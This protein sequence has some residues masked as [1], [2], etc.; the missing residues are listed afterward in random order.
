MA[1]PVADVNL[2]R[3]DF[4]TYI[5]NTPI[6]DM[7]ASMFPDPK[8]PITP[9]AF[10]SDG[11]QENTA[12]GSFS[13]LSNL[14][15]KE[16]KK[17]FNQNTVLQV[18]V[19]Q[20]DTS[21][22]FK[23]FSLGVDNEDAAA[24]GQSG[25]DKAANAVTKGLVL[26]GTTFLQGTAGLVA[27]V[28]NAIADGKLS[29]FYD[30]GFNRTLDGWNKQLENKYLPNYYSKSE[31][32]ASWYSPD[33]WLTVNFLFDK[34]VKNL[35][36]AAGAYFSGGVASKALSALGSVSKLT[37]VG[38][39]FEAAAEAEKLLL[40]QKNSFE[41]INDF[42]Q[43]LKTISNNA[44]NKYNFLNTG[45][46]VLAAGLSTV[47][48]ASFESMANAAQGREA[49]IASFQTKYGRLPVGEEMQN[50]DAQAGKIG[51]ASFLLNTALLSVTNYIQFPK[52]MGTSYKAAK[53]IANDFAV[54]TNTIVKD[55]EKGEFR[56]LNFNKAARIA[57]GV[58]T[59]ASYAFSP[60]EAFEEV[61]QTAIQFGT[62]SYYDKKYRGQEANF[63][64]DL[65]GE[66]YSKAF[67]TKEGI[68]SLI[69]GGLS[70]AIME[71]PGR[72]RTNKTLKANTA[73]AISDLN[74]QSFSKFM[75]DT[76]DAVNRGITLQEQQEAA[77]RQG[78]ILEAK[79]LERDYAHNYLMPRVKYGRYDLVKD[80][81]QSYKR[82]ASTEEGF[83]QLQAEGKA[84]STDTVASFMARLDNF[85]KHAD[86]M[87]VFYESFN[88]RYKGIVDKDK[89]RVYSDK[90]IDKM[91]YA[92]S[93]VE[94]Y[95]TR[96]K[97]LST[98][99]MASGIDTTKLGQFEAED[100]TGEEYRTIRDQIHQLPLIDT[101]KEA[102]EQDLNDFVELALRRKHFLQE[103][104]NLKDNPAEH[105]E[106]EAEESTT[107][108][109][110]NG[111]QKE[112]ASKETVSI[113]T[114]DGE[115][116]VKIGEEYYLGRLV[117]FDTKG[118][119]VYRFPRL[120][121]IGKNEDG[122]I[123]IKQSD[124]KIRD[125]SPEEFASYKLGRVADVQKRK[126]AKYFLEHIN[127]IFEFNFGKTKGGKK[128]GRIQY[129]PAK[130]ILE[131]IYKDSKGKIKRRE[132]TGDQFKAKKGYTEPLIKSIGTLTPVQQEALD[133]MAADKEDERIQKKFEQRLQIISEL[134]TNHRE[135]I[136]QINAK[137]DENNKSLL[138]SEGQ[139]S[140]LSKKVDKGE[141]DENN[142]FKAS[143]RT[144]VRTAMKLSRMRDEWTKE[145]ESLL[146]E[147]EELEMGL[148]YFD[149]LAADLEELPTNTSEFLEE[150]KEQQKDVEDLI[151]ATGNSINK[152]A[153]L[154][155]KIEDGIASAIS[156]INSIID[157]FTSTYPKAPTDSQSQ[158]LVDFVRANPNFLK[159]HPGFL[160]DL[161]SLEALVT[162]SEDKEI[163]V[164]QQELNK[165]QGQ[166]DDLQTTL[167][168]LESEYRAKGVVYEKF[169]GIAD[170]S[171]DDKKK[172]QEFEANKKLQQ[173]LF[174]Q[175]KDQDKD[176]G[177]PNT[178]GDPGRKL[179]WAATAKHIA[180]LFRSSTSPSKDLKPHHIREQALL[181]NIKILPPELRANLRIV[182]ITP[183]TQEAMGLPGLIDKIGGDANTIVAV[184]AKTNEGK[185]EYIDINGQPTTFLD[186]AV[187][188]TMPTESLTN[189]SGNQRYSQGTEE[190][191]KAHQK[192]W[193][194]KRAE[195]L[196]WT[197]DQHA[198]F[199]FGISRGI[200]VIT[201]REED[202]KNK[203]EQNNAVGTLIQQSDLSK[204][205]LVQVSVNGTILHELG[206]GENI[207]QRDVN[208]PIGNVVIQNQDTIAILNNRNFTPSEQEGLYKVLRQFVSNSTNG[209]DR[210]LAQYLQG[211]FHFSR[212]QEGK[213]PA[214]NQ[215]WIEE[216]KLHLGRN[217]SVSFYPE[218]FD[219]AKPEV[220]AFL[221]GVYNNANNTKLKENK[222]YEE[223]I[224][225]DSKGEPVSVTWKSYQH[226]L[227]SPTHDLV[228][229]DSS[230]LKGKDRGLAPLTTI[231][232]P[233]NKEVNALDSNFEQKYAT[234]IG[235]FYPVPEKKIIPPAPKEIK[236]EEPKQEKNKVQTPAQAKTAGNY[237]LDGKTKNI[238]S[239]KSGDLAFTMV[240]EGDGYNIQILG[241]IPESVK[242]AIY[243]QPDYLA[244]AASN[245][246]DE[247]AVPTVANM[248]ILA[249]VK[250]A[251]Q[252]TIPEA[253]ITAE[254][255]G[256]PV[257]PNI[258][259]AESIEK[260]KELIAK[261]KASGAVRKKD[262]E[263]RLLVEGFDYVKANLDQEQSWFE[264]VLSI[265]FNR[266]RNIINAGG[267]GIAFGKFQDAAVHIWENAEIGTTYHEAFE[268]VWAMFTDEKEKAAILKE[269][270]GRTGSFVERET[271]NPINHSSSTDVQAKEQL[272]EEFRNYVIDGAKP[273]KGWLATLF[274]DLLDFIKELFHPEQ[275]IQ[276]MFQRINGG[277]YKDAA[278]LNQDNI[279]DP[280]YSII[281]N[282]KSQ[283]ASSVVEHV[284]VSLLRQINKD[285]ASTHLVELDENTALP[286][287]KLFDMV[288]DE[289]RDWY[290][291][292]AA[293]DNEND[294]VLYSKY[295]GVWNNIQNNWRAVKEATVESLRAY[296]IVAKLAEEDTDLLDETREEGKS[297]EEKNDK[298]SAEYERPTFTYDVK[299]NAPTSIK[300]LFANLTE[301]IASAAG[302][303]V[304]D[305]DKLTSLEQQ[306]KYT[307]IFNQTMGALVDVNT[308][309][310]KQAALKDLMVKYPTLRK[311]YSYLKF[312]NSSP[313]IDDWRLRVR[314]FNVFSKQQPS[315]LINYIT[316]EGE[317]FVG[318]ADL[319]DA[320]Q[321]LTKKW[322]ES[323]KGTVGKPGSII[324]IGSD[325]KQYMVK[326]DV[327]RKYP[328][329]RIED[330]LAMLN[331]IGI[332][333]TAAQ[334]NLLSGVDK[335]RFNKGVTDLKSYLGNKNNLIAANAK[336][337]DVRGPFTALAETYIKSKGEEWES[338][339]IDINGE[340]VQKSI[341]TNYISNV[342]NDINNSTSLED[343]YQRLPHLR[344][345]EYSQGSEYLKDFSNPDNKPQFKIKYIQGTIDQTKTNKQNIP[346]E[347]LNPAERLVQEINQNLEGNYYVL[348]P[349]DS[350]TEWILGMQNRVDF[351]TIY[352]QSN[353]W[354][355]INNIFEGYYQTE[356]ALFL[357]DGKLRPMAAM[358]NNYKLDNISGAIKE[359][360]QKSVADQAEFLRSY[361]KGLNNFN[362][363]FVQ[364]KFKEERTEHDLTNLL[365]YRTA[366]Y[367]IN[368][369]ETHKLFFGDPAA[370]KDPT[371][372]YKSF[373]SPREASLYGSDEYT[374]IA[375]ESFNNA[376]DIKL[377][378][379][380][381]G[382]WVFDDNMIVAV[383]DDIISTTSST[384][385]E[386]LR[387]AYTQTNSAD[388]QSWGTIAGYREIWKRAGDRWS[389]AHEAQY[390]YLMAA[391]RQ[392]MLKDG[393]LNDE[394]YRKEL[395]EED[396]KIVKHGNPHSTFFPVLKPIGSGFDLEDRPFLHKTSLVP[397]W[398]R[399]TKIDGKPTNLTTHYLRMMNQGVSYSIVTSGEKVGNAGEDSV[400]DEKGNAKTA[401]TGF[402]RLVDIPF[403][404]Y[405]IQVETNSNKSTGV[406]GTQITKEVTMN[407]LDDSGPVD[408]EG[409]NWDT[410]SEDQK[411]AA[412]PI[413]TQVRRN[414]QLLD[415]MTR[416]GY[417]KLLKKFGIID[418]GD[419]FSMPDKSLALK[420]IQDELFRREVPD[421]F[422]SALKLDSS[423]G[424][425]QV[426]LEALPNYGQIQAIILSY[427]DKLITSPK[428][429]GGA[430]VQVSGAMWE[431]IGARE[432]KAYNKAGKE[433][434]A[435]VS[436]GLKFYQPTYNADGSIKS[437]GRM[438]VLLPNWVGKKLRERG[439]TDE[440]ILSKMTPE[441]LQGVG[442]RI[443]TQEINS[444]E[445]FI[446]KGFLP[447]EYGS[448]IVVPEE[449][450][451]KA[452][453]DFDVDKLNTYLKNIH[454][455]RTG[456]IHLIEYQGDE[457]STRQFY[458][459]FFD[460]AI[461]E[462]KKLN[463]KSIEGTA[464]LFN[465]AE[466]YDLDLLSE[467]QLKKHERLLNEV[468]ASVDQ[469]SDLVE[470]L[471]D[472]LEKKGKIAADLDDVELQA[473]L[474]D[475]FV[476]R[477]HE[478][479]LEN[480]YFKSVEQLILL[481]ENFERL[482]TPNS[483]DQLKGLR[484]DLL[485]ILPQEGGTDKSILNPLFM[486]QTR[487]NFIV[488]KGGVGI[489]AVAQTNHAVNQ[490]SKVYIDA[491][492]AKKLPK[493]TQD[494]LG[495]L[496]IKL[497]H[498]TTTVAGKQVPTLSKIKNAAGQH[499]SN[500]IAQFIDGYVDIAKDPF[501]VELGATPN[502]AGTFLLLIKLGVPVDTVVYFMNQPI[503][504]SH[505]KALSS[506]GTTW[507][508][509]EEAVQT[510]LDLFATNSK[511]LQSIDEKALRS[512]IDTYTKKGELSDVK[513]A[514]QQLI[515]LEFL[516]Y[517]MM[518]NQLFEFTQ[519]TNYDTANF[520]DGGLV[521]K[522]IKK[523]SKAEQSNIFSSP[524]SY[525]NNSHMGGMRTA[526]VNSSRA[527]GTTMLK[528]S[529]PAVREQLGKV[530]D[531]FDNL[532]MTDKDYIN[533]VRKIR[534][535]F[536]SFL[537]QTQR[538][539]NKRVHELLV[540][541]NSNIATRIT[542]AIN[543]AK[544]GTAM[545]ENAFI[546]NIAVSYGA[547]T[548][549]TKGINLAIKVNGDAF[550]SD[551]IT[552]GLAELKDADR[553]LYRAVV[554][555]AF[556][557][558]GISKTAYSFSDLIPAAD[559]AEMLN[560]L[561]QNLENSAK[562][563]SFADYDGFIRNN[564]KDP[565]IVPTIKEKI[566]RDEDGR[567]VGGNRLSLGM[568]S[569]L[570]ERLGIPE[571]EQFQP[572]KLNVRNRHA[573]RKFIAIRRDKQGFGNKIKKEM[574]KKKD[575]S[576]MEVV[577]LKRIDDENGEPVTL[578]KKNNRK[579]NSVMYFPMN[580]W[581]DGYAAQEYYDVPTKSVLN[582]GTY[583]PSAEA[584]SEDV[585]NALEGNLA[586]VHQKL[587]RAIDTGEI[588]QN[589]D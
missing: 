138:E 333:F 18:P 383:I 122:T 26:A 98:Y 242:Q 509:G 67:N 507:L 46:R 504:K 342:V 148:A 249:K 477:M 416:V 511:A 167:K 469:T 497:S 462:A 526:L 258:G 237:I 380:D 520:S 195:I 429:N 153:T 588:K 186:E 428:V 494:I 8:Q 436:R 1:A 42:N 334:Y 554:R 173:M 240:Q 453:S 308:L 418:H 319:S 43:A 495:D 490:L 85:E 288:Y 175:Q 521:D 272:A 88:L 589:C 411:K 473:I 246:P 309:Q 377:Q 483:A 402:S 561:L 113:T 114:K 502:T 327:L 325:Y 248:F 259:E 539:L 302:E 279:V 222:P 420:L 62:Q 361:G 216:G 479:A 518:A 181:N 424:D 487:H 269:F 225:I 364:S 310:E 44:I 178:G 54:A 299:K 480:E 443:P 489:A 14:L 523:T 32:D 317:T 169:Q 281:P 580:A 137:I 427:V 145:N 368:N 537:L 530:V 84:A 56:T 125:V 6:P 475:I 233:L 21:G 323:F 362:T 204:K 496:S 390:Q 284:R 55:A 45:H 199:A 363:Q 91:V 359:Y 131:F 350:K 60:S 434:K 498:N 63:F 20:I 203:Y 550:T 238:A 159:I 355:K 271:G 185:L 110:Q 197:G 268:A 572:Y 146:G 360:I 528:L 417:Q 275:R 551:I 345:H 192:A 35:G 412:S 438:E 47:G 247:R 134:V 30:N 535:G 300:F 120:T 522:K 540:D 102:L 321:S 515:L 266:V 373:L 244:L 578:G 77:I 447:E 2:Q 128:K 168:G 267:A 484:K 87:N 508:Y 206:Y 236:K 126:K 448:T 298:S 372:R 303:T 305:R 337:L 341:Q 579:Y 471:M 210:R 136:N 57:K 205:G 11:A 315:P 482:I 343:L 330:K 215:M 16:P 152:T 70:G 189:L 129:N 234:I 214:R 374:N 188:A 223:I 405:G 133:A 404:Y 468:L 547:T 143:T 570:R 165:L 100:Y 399:G 124:G 544:P 493:D 446:V 401:D 316:E 403:K 558:S 422:K 190:E 230:P 500:I 151:L 297:D 290:E 328:T 161:R 370:Y 274:S 80:D 277:Y 356:K 499:I 326:Q 149:D 184:Y 123:K 466:G 312:D 82:L 354:N 156:F 24:A 150:L 395:Q 388:A 488:G 456:E 282:F 96:T 140:K 260:A 525:L 5:A 385:P 170:K 478:K 179:G 425:F 586:S 532:Y 37:S 252:S 476:D 273:K 99:L 164:P 353:F 283:V 577:L 95:S 221:S 501:I 552:E 378:E 117:K 382:H 104:T 567:I 519:A 50:I 400:Y 339:F 410:L 346:T 445:A 256:E 64:D 130:D 76:A 106:P 245:V 142:K 68:E 371:K 331:A 459:E 65:L 103:F 307:R 251:Q 332:P 556:L 463:Q 227:L 313:S 491:E 49:M 413:Y 171:K 97:E 79:D 433:Y 538:G 533:V 512:N 562:Y 584:T 437:V 335:S 211:V 517:S 440:E 147:R 78:D 555:A 144:A 464:F 31:T 174:A 553:S 285:G 340:K 158:E 176:A 481:P 452:G 53:S 352:N 92:A 575:F 516:K 296:G 241:E 458:S 527:I 3:P 457:A 212:P 294:P 15:A 132:V 166:L 154:I 193:A 546:Q 224:D 541:E 376:G 219:K 74:T 435:V 566:V 557:Q 320:A 389:N 183:K 470:L 291:V 505:L 583:K 162:S 379:G 121:I 431:E 7:N 543:S 81:I 220:M 322:I 112:T 450:T 386:S 301:T 89:Q 524:S 116:N 207:E 27:G 289:M 467:E 366:N 22:R 40:A 73:L 455:K 135:R 243:L 439:F 492:K 253:T 36:F 209:I 226:F 217:F 397:L 66:G 409:T 318:S 263:Y 119:E 534:E 200:P 338:T 587:V 304:F 111:E 33:N 506:A 564:W 324:E 573:A 394:N 548:T 10:L 90:V 232:R 23:F 261:A 563:T 127:D 108:A 235:D 41:S 17:G 270:R 264:R 415:E 13:R 163:V 198:S 565:S 349:A 344:Y 93:K 172:E 569:T 375:N 59:G 71:G 208:V 139:L 276:K 414:T 582:N 34:V 571:G 408:Y 250:A 442:F 503:I 39:S 191:A 52:I 101:T 449:I 529:Q 278:P 61:S 514:E 348:I 118:N 254:I 12:D 347:K 29:S 231:I 292:Q 86:S 369:I 280:Q 9:G 423:T 293:I 286:L 454:V 365:T 38:K 182:L 432:V 531:A 392:E 109:Q 69:I 461:Q 485:S 536:I 542:A 460:T 581:G 568:L 393:I 105:T 58:K 155:K 75:S 201:V 513:N 510:Q 257:T 196:S 187:Y 486:S 314:F 384:L 387:E 451:T 549:S 4:D 51:K 367:M 560:P 465:L 83:A 19:D 213:Q 576:Y 421:N 228:E 472:K 336:T 559:Y 177:I 407:L 94:D 218:A 180:D 115:E 160:D 194:D 141:V 444:M 295:L 430:R 311:L 474:K 25:L 585:I 358:S 28:G 306:A 48:E 255:K 107:V 398:Y 391:D 419:R 229:E 287:D 157:K 545:A 574:A 426:A 265:P 406:R 381:F 441:M 202:G 351:D 239:F 72:F 357:A 262:S 329:G 396:Q